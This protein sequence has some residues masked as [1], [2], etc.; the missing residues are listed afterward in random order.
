MFAGEGCSWVGERRRS[1]VHRCRDWPLKGAWQFTHG[2]R[3]ETHLH[4]RNVSCDCRSLLS[5]L[6][7]EMRSMV[8]VEICGGLLD[9]R[10]KRRPLVLSGTVGESTMWRKRCF[11][12]VVP[13][14]TAS[15]SPESMSGMQVLGAALE[16]LHPKLWHQAQPSVR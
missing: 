3:K 10:G 13:G 8:S 2:N 4:G 5:S 1:Q 6:L 11:L 12:S 16:L 7:H 15:V 9:I 14:P